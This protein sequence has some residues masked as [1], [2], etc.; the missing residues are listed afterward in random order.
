[1][2]SLGSQWCSRGHLYRSGFGFALRFYDNW[3]TLISSQFHRTHSW[4]IYRF[5]APFSTLLEYIHLVPRPTDERSDSMYTASLIHSN[6]FSQDICLSSWG[7]MD[8]FRIMGYAPHTLGRLSSCSMQS[9][10]IGWKWF[11]CLH[12]FTISCVAFLLVDVPS[13]L[14]SPIPFCRWFHVLHSPRAAPQRLFI[15]RYNTWA[16]VRAAMANP[17]FQLAS[18]DTPCDQLVAARVQRWGLVIDISTT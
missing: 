1:M 7:K 6:S 3:R 15:D 4:P 13:L 8:V 12:M 9:S 11:L 2:S 14:T 16:S 5:P 18:I 17:V 10:T